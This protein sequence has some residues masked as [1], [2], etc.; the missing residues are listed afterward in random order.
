MLGHALEIEGRG[1]PRDI[2]TVIPDG[3]LLAGDAL[4]QPHEAAILFHGERAEPGVAHELQH[5]GDRVFLE[6]DLVDA[7]L[8]GLRVLVAPRLVDDLVGQLVLVQLP[9]VDGAPIRI[10]RPSLTHDDG[11]DGGLGRSMVVIDA[12]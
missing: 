4:S 3:D 9:D 2:E 8:D 5:L 10:A 7:G 6:H 11:V 1:E 12:E